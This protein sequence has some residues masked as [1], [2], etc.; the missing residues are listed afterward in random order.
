MLVQIKTACFYC[1]HSYTIAYLEKVRTKNKYKKNCWKFSVLV[2][3]KNRDLIA[4]QLLVSVL[5]IAVST[6]T[7]IPGKFFLHLFNILTV[8]ILRFIY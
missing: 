6:N 1:V 8:N 2:L 3:L 4:S 5:S 7:E